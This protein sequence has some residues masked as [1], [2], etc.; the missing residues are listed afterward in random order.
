MKT[1]LIGLISLGCLRTAHA[2]E[3]KDNPDRYISIGLNVSQEHLAG[4]NN[5]L[6]NPNTAS[7]TL[8]PQTESLNLGAVG[9]DVRVPMFKQFTFMFSYE[10][11]TLDSELIRSG[12]T[13][14][15]HAGLRGDRFSM[16]VRFYLVK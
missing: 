10:K 4:D 5:N 12:N 11:L 3:V 13:F 16:G 15:S 14:Q 8:Q 6:L 2:W 9:Y 1:L 7:E